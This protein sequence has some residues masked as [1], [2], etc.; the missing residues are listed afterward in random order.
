MWL[1][2]QEV[3]EASREE[4]REV[5]SCSSDPASGAQDKCVKAG[6]FVHCSLQS[7]LAQLFL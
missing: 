2:L 4:E 3:T 7:L 1:V 6:E 5:M